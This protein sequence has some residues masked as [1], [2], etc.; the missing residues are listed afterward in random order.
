M[1]ITS[2]DAQRVQSGAEC[3]AT[4]AQ[5]QAAI[6]RLARE[7]TDK[8][9]GH[10][11]LFLCVLTGGIILTTVAA[12][13]FDY[14]RQVIG[15][16]RVIAPAVRVDRKRAE[17]LVVTAVLETTAELS[18]RLGYATTDTQAVAS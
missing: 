17:T 2:S 1:P 4:N 15:A 7:L 8:V 9:G 18:R 14:N 13:V 16:I 12:P 3:L 10:D 5:V 6:D 11:P